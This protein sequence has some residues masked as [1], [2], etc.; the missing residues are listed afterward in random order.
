MRGVEIDNELVGLGY[1]ARNLVN[2][3]END[4]QLGWHGSVSRIG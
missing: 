1:T 2:E 3:I 4:G